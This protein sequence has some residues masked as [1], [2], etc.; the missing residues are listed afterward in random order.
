MA[1]LC[2]AEGYRRESEWQVLLDFDYEV[3]KMGGGSG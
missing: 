3:G 2:L 1:K